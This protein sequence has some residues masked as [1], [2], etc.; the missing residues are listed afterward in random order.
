MSKAIPSALQWTYRFSKPYLRGVLLLALIGS[1]IAIGF[2]LLA[3]LSGFI[4]DS[5]SGPNETVLWPWI[6]G[7]GLLVLLQAL[8][9]GVASEVRARISGRMEMDLKQSLFSSLNR[10]QY[11]PLTQLHSGDV[12]HRLT[13][14]V[15]AIVH[16]VVQ[17]IPQVISMGIRLIAGFIVLMGINSRFSL[18]IAGA[19]LL[20]YGAGKLYR[21]RYQGLH[22]HCQQTEGQTR[23]FIQECLDNFLVVKSFGQEHPLGQ[24]LNERQQANYFAKLQRNT[25]TTIAT[26]S[27]YLMVATGYFAVL[28]WGA[29]QLSAGAMTLG[30]LLAFLQIMQQMKAPF[31][32][33]SGLTPQYYAMLASAERLQ[34][35]EH[36]PDEPSQE[37]PPLTQ[38][39]Y[40]SLTAIEFDHVGFGYSRGFTT[41]EVFQTM[42]FSIRKGEFIGIAG[43]S[44]SGKSTLLKLI[45]GLMQP[46]AGSIRFLLNHGSVE[47]GE[48]SRSMFAYVPQA[49]LLFSGTVRE[50]ITLFNPALSERDVDHALYV[51]CLGEEVAA[52]PRGQ[53]TMLGER[54]SGLSE[55]QA[56][57]LS[58]AR[59]VASGAPILLLDEC[60][61]ALDARMEKDV[62][63]RLRRLPGRTII[64]ISHSLAALASCDR[65]IDIGP[66]T[67]RKETGH[68]A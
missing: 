5:A 65:L 49:N 12:I 45:L 31:Q 66:F 3:V 59:A 30:A 19:G 11:L 1:A 41:H 52:M 61:S 47:L 53:D 48:A 29:F 28:C 43:V 34:E 10:K 23:S 27:T 22:K 17:I 20:L 58:I 39:S 16:T 68:G 24:Q 62:L 8:L 55:G 9:Y 63:S 6:C 36:I 18:M 54:H 32:S 57:R 50:N 35:L 40:A 2:V 13:S 44:G 25:V 4:L 51:A 64:L 15:Q 14:D 38:R 26:S 7:L 37:G 21:R 42:R 33:M 46:H 56:Q 60:T 67:H